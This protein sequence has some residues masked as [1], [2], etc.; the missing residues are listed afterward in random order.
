MHLQGLS[1][2]EKVKLSEGSLSNLKSVKHDDSRV[3]RGAVMRSGGGVFLGVAE[4]GS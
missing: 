4:R 2:M 1:D 3:G